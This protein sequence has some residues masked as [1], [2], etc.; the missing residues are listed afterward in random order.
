[1]FIKFST[2]IL[3]RKSFPTF[4]TESL[5]SEAIHTKLE[6]V[7]E[8]QINDMSDINNCVSNFSNTM[9]HNISSQ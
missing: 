6:T 4:Y 9:C 3:V 5:Q 7:L 1:M 8:T 2:V